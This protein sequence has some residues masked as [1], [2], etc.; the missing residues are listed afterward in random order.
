M[1]KVDLKVLKMREKIMKYKRIK[2]FTNVTVEILRVAELLSRG[3]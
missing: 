2:S 1:L 3:K